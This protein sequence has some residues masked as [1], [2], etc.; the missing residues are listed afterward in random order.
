M[1]MHEKIRV[2]RELNKWSQEE[3]AEKLDMTAGGYARIERGE[4]KLNIPRL[5]Q[6]AAIFQVDAWDLLQSGKSGVVFQINEGDSGGDISLS[7]T[8]DTQIEVALIKQ[9]L[10]HCKE[11]LA[12]KD[13]EIELL[14]QIIQTSKSE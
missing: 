12:Q 1:E 14:R 3:I 13:K 7:V 11:L 5:E 10:K 2:L 6:L 4:V 8:S 9:E